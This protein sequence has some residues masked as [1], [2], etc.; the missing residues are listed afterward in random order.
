MLSCRPGIVKPS[1]YIRQPLHSVL[2]LK[3][4]KLIHFLK[5]LDLLIPSSNMNNE[6]YHVSLR[7]S[8]TIN[9]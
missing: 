7:D 5:H 9:D 6:N 8:L 1:K 4:P 3:I 2:V